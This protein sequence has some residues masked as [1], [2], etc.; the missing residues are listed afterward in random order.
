M[1]N[2][3]LISY[4]LVSESAIGVSRAEKG[5]SS[6]QLYLIFRKVDCFLEVK[7][8][9]IQQ[10]YSTTYTHTKRL[11]PI[12]FRENIS[13]FSIYVNNYFKGYW[14]KRRIHESLLSI[15]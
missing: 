14:N 13:L 9:F 8:Y 11:N 12:V 2:T 10:D 6:I 3:A 5:Q 7:G 4:I 1:L 15:D